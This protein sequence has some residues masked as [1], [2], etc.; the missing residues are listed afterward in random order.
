[1]LSRAV[2][3]AA[4]FVEFGFEEF[5]LVSW[6]PKSHEPGICCSG[7]RADRYERVNLMQMFRRPADLKAGP[8]IDHGTS[9]CV[10]N[11]ERT[12]GLQPYAK[13]KLRIGDVL[14]QTMNIG[15]WDDSHIE[16]V[17]ASDQVEVGE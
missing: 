10:V 15:L 5:L 2:D 12:D 1:M 9:P 6:T 11:Y 8:H 16:C 3:L 13:E 7:A 17:S 4:V 14:D